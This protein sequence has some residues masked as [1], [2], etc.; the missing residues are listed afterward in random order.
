MTSSPRLVAFLI[1]HAALGLAMNQVSI[2][3]FIHA[4]VTILIALRLAGTIQPERVAP[5]LGYVTGCEV[6]WRM[7]TDRL[8][9]ELGK[10]AVILVCG[11]AI[12]RARGMRGI[13]P[14]LMCFSLLL[15][16][17]VLTLMDFPAGEARQQISF[18]LS[19][20]LALAMSAAFFLVTRPSFADV[21]RIFLALMGPAVSIA[22]LALFGILTNPDLTFNTESNFAT[23]GGFGP[24]Q[25]SSMLGLGALAAFYVLVMSETWPPRLIAFAVMGWLATQCALTFSRG[26][27][28]AAGGA[29]LVSLLFFLGDRRMRLWVAPVAI[30][31]VLLGRYAVWPSLDQFTDGTITARFAEAEMT[32]RDDLGAEDLTAWYENPVFGIGPGRSSLVHDER[33]IAHTEFTR[34][35][36]EHGSLGAAAMVLLLFAVVR[37]IRRSGSTKAMG[38]SAGMTAWACLFMVNSAMRTAAP[39]FIFGLA[40]AAIG[41]RVRTARLVQPVPLPLRVPGLTPFRRVWSAAD[42]HQI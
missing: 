19:G 21:E 42:E 28:F 23:S 41:P 17:A 27:L 3:V 9:W 10:Y 38:F 20:P 22:S 12:V 32:R 34:L 26:G 33:I 36:A 31:V 8:P 4:L 6:L 11:V 40:F 30:A 2:L 35:L 39:S 15:P 29:A 37:N 7:T 18:N 16:S 24:N 5:V 13:V 25:V 1:A 14:P